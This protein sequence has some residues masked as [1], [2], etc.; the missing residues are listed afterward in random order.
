MIS[1]DHII[2][3]LLTGAAAGFAG[4]MLGIGGAFIM[5]PIQLIVYSAMGLP[6]DLA[7]KTAFGTSM[8]VILPAAISG[9]WRHHRNKAVMWKAAVIMGVCSLVAA[10]F[11]S[12]L[13]T[14]LPG[15]GL[16]I[17]FGVV[18]LLTAVRMATAREPQ[19]KIEAVSQPWQW[20]VW[21]IPL[22]F[23][24]GMFGI[25]GGVVM[26]PVLVL[27]LRFEMHYAIG[28]SLAIIMLTSLGGILGYII[29]GIGV[30][31][32]LEYSLGYVNIPSWLLLMVPAA[33]MAQVG[34]VVAHK[35]PRKLL[36]YIFIIVLLYMG[37]RMVGLFEWLGWP[38]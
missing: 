10:F 27:A 38:L 18:V 14:H 9:S 29:N 22:G 36:L 6:E 30:E 13:A 3:L 31:G 24:A 19:Y 8:L 28:T 23:V 12:T 35:M 20:I 26:I 37:L 15:S 32:R 7:V 4:G 2:L 21:A 34:A 17:A 1:P 5:T 25:G 11:G 33:I 16:K